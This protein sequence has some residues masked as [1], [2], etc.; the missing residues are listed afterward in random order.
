VITSLKAACLS[1]ACLATLG[2]L[3]CT[4]ASANRVGLDPTF[5]K[6]GVVSIPTQLDPSP[7]ISG[8]VMQSD[9]KPIVASP[10]QVIRLLPDGKRDRSFQTTGGPTSALALDRA[11]GILRAQD[12][13]LSRLLP[14]GRPDPAFGSGGSVEIPGAEITTLQALPD[15]SLLAGG[16]LQDGT[17]LLVAR[18]DPDGQ[19]DTDFGK[20]G[21]VTTQIAFPGPIGQ[22]PIN[23]LTSL[24]SLPSGNIVAAGQTGQGQPSNFLCEHCRNHYRAVVLR[25]LPDGQLDASFGGA[26]VFTPSADWGSAFAVVPGPGETTRFL[27]RAG[28]SEDAVTKTF[29]QG[30]AI[31]ALTAGG[32]PLQRFGTSGTSGYFEDEFYGEGPRAKAMCAWPGGGV[33]VAGTA[34]GTKSGFKLLFLRADGSLD[35]EVSSRGSVTTYLGG[36]YFGQGAEAI[37]RSSDHGLVVAGWAAHRIVVARYRMASSHST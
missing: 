3:N 5:G 34:G 27:L 1:L 12:S 20:G 8:L 9:G 7:N 29:T 15:G 33:V 28:S 37:A 36:H 2:V 4:H 32:Y 25:Y 6:N 13:K 24:A 23:Q 11:G 26:G 10:E 16:G 35:T 30:F 21:I 18:F 19:L 14:S 17:G 31:G 22:V